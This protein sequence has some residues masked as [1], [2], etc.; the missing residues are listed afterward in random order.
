M[1]LNIL[2]SKSFILAAVGGSLALEEDFVHESIVGTHFTGRLL[3][4]VLITSASESIK[5]VVPTIS[6][7]A[8]I[9][10]YCDV[11]CDPSDPFPEGYLVGDIWSGTDE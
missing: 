3:E 4:E 1:S 6:G 2:L 9:T 10:Q 8:W 7:R 5:A 11:V